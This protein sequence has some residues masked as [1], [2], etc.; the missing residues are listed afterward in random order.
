MGEFQP[1]THAFMIPFID[2]ELMEADPA[3]PTIATIYKVKIEDLGDF[4]RIFNLLG[5]EFRPLYNLMEWN[6]DPDQP[7]VM[8]RI[9]G[10][11]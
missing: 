11:K 8:E 5:T 2:G 3:R 6:G 7:S 10:K 4:K 1:A 9:Q